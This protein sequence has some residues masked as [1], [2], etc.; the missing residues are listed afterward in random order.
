VRIQ[1]S[2]VDLDGRKIDFRLVQEHSGMPTRAALDRPAQRDS[3]GR[4][5]ALEP[6]DADLSQRTPFYQGTERKRSSEKSARPAR[7]ASKASPTRNKSTGK[8]R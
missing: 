5:S 4:A 8:R 7:S 6:G 3:K 1:V 2:R